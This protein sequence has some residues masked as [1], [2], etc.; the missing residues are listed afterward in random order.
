MR[1]KLLLALDRFEPGQ[2]AA[3]FTVGLAT[4]SRSDVQVLHVRELPASL[5]IPPLESATEAEVLVEETVRRLQ[6]AGIAAEGT[7]CADREANVARR[8]VDGAAGRRCSAIVLGSLRLK[9]FRSW[10][11][12]GTRERVLRLSPL[13][14]IVTPPALRIDQRSAAHL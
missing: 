12:H 8:I 13:P 10:M 7:A 6:T 5:Q 4:M 11:G 9:R 14:V 2:A 1:G 3:D